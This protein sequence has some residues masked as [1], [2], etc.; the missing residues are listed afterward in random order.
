VSLGEGYYDELGCFGPAI[1]EAYLLESSKANGAI[2]PTIKL[3]DSLGAFLFE[4]ESGVREQFDVNKY[5][6]PRPF[7]LKQDNGYFVNL[8]YGIEGSLVGIDGK[9]FARNVIASA[10]GNRQSCVQAVEKMNW[11]IQTIADEKKAISEAPKISE[12]ELVRKLL[13]INGQN[14]SAKD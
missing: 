7:I 10:E 2:Y 3:H 13:A 14:N 4:Y 8:F 9:S 11:I 6:S 5:L 12:Q 1:E